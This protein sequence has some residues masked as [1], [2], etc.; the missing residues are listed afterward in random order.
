MCNEMSRGKEENKK[1][2]KKLEEEEEDHLHTWHGLV[3]LLLKRQEES[4]FFFL[5]SCVLLQ[6]GIP[7]SFFFFLNHFVL[8]N[9]NYSRRRYILGKTQNSTNIGG[10]FLFLSLKFCLLFGAVGPAGFPFSSETADGH[11]RRV[12][13]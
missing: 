11:T 5:Y 7:A 1:K 8:S 3:L 12:G 10:V 6:L 9:R 13:S 4:F 2:Q